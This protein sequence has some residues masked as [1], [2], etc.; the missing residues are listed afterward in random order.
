[1]GM[2]ERYE[3]AK[4]RLLTDPEICAAN[5]ALFTAFFTYEEYKLKRRNGKPALDDNS[6]RTLLDYT[7]RLRV[8]NRWFENKSWRHLTQ[9][10]IRR[11]YDDLEDG[12]ILTSRGKP[13]RDKRTYYEKIIRSKPFAMAGKKDLVL[14]VMQFPPHHNEEEVRFFPEQ[15]FRRLADVAQKTQHRLFLWLCFD[16]G[17][18]ASSILKLRKRDCMRQVN[19]HTKEP[20]YIVNLR[21]EILKRTRRARS[22]LT[23]YRET[24][25]YLDLILKALNEDD[26]LFSFGLG[27]ARKLFDRAIEKTAVRC[28]PN[29]QRPTLK[30]LR[31][32]MACDLLSK[33]WSGDEVNA[34]LGHTPS[35]KEIDRYISYF[36]IDRAR[37]KRKFHETEISKYNDRIKHLEETNIRLSREITS[38]KQRSVLSQQMG[39]VLVDFTDAL[40]TYSDG[41]ILLKDLNPRLEHGARE[42][43]ILQKQ[44][45]LEAEAASAGDD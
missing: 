18:N 41:G 10:D 42:L 31:S 44:W 26:L 2:K 43:R 34:R 11:V 45:R 12:R 24:I 40:L 39:A 16:I 23:N 35:S 25:Q 33:G 8:V 9:E 15:D 20:E 5:R 30:D 19:E 6:L 17:E 22:E 13:L 1:M 28:R 38:L 21:R 27:G 4:T 37:P 29:G 14:E 7:S 3:R 32:S 36:A